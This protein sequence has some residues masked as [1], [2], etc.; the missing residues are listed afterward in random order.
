MQPQTSTAPRTGGVVAG[1]VFD[2]RESGPL[3]DLDTLVSGGT[4][5]RAW[6]SIFTVI[7]PP[8]IGW[9]YAFDFP[10]TEIAFAP[11]T[12]D[13]SSVTDASTFAYENDWSAGPATLGEFFFLRNINTGFYAAIR[14]DSIHGQTNPE[15]KVDVTWYLQT[16]GNPDFSSFIEFDDF[17]S[18]DLSFWSLVVD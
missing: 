3:L 18:G 2:W 16:D 14:V 13:V 7:N 17:E 10:D 1:R 5:I 12:T 9:F 6:W 11:N 8:P 4:G 15:A